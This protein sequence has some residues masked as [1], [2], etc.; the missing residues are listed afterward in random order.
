MTNAASIKTKSKKTRQALSEYGKI[1][2]KLGNMKKAQL[3]K[4]A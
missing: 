2:G 1:L 3:A 4:N